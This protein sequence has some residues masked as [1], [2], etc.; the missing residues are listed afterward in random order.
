[1]DPYSKITCI[2]VTL[3]KAKR[4]GNVVGHKLSKQLNWD[5]YDNSDLKFEDYDHLR[6]HSTL[7]LF[8]HR[9]S[10]Y[11]NRGL[12][13]ADK[14]IVNCRHNH[15]DRIIIG[16]KCINGLS[17]YNNF[18]YL[19]QSFFPT[20]VVEDKLKV[21]KE[22]IAL[23]YYFRDIRYDGAMYFINDL[24]PKIDKNIPIFI[25]GISDFPYIK[26]RKII[27]TFDSDYFFNNI[28][29]YF[30][31]KSN[32]ILDPFPHSL[33]EALQKGCTLI[34]PENKKRIYKDGID[35]ILSLT[36]GKYISKIEN[37]FLE[38][39]FDL[40]LNLSPIIK[41]QHKI[42][43]SGFTLMPDKKWKTLYDLMSHI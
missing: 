9:P 39:V 23:G 13:G 37:N 42:I 35:D 8:N 21:K 6:E 2:Y 17:Y 33:L 20:V 7:F 36:C 25:L 12:I 32:I 16:R 43:E 22:K 34:V 27:C 31:F 5:C 1:M 28:T 30:Y 40:N 4:S 38:K 19:Y 15:I 14:D 18:P 26:D 41:Y 11:T 29:H 24:L 10:F 3:G